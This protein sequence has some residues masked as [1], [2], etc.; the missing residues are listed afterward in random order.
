MGIKF[1]EKITIKNLYLSYC[2]QVQHSQKHDKSPPSNQLPP[3]T[4]A[5][6][7]SWCNRLHYG[8][9]NIPPVL[10]VDSKA[11]MDTRMSNKSLAIFCNVGLLRSIYFSPQQDI[12]IKRL[13]YFILLQIVIQ[14]K[15]TEA[16]LAFFFLHT[17][18]SK[19][20]NWSFIGQW[21][22]CIKLKSFSCYLFILALNW[23]SLSNS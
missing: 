13:R 21:S 9:N 15:F 2:L 19:S 14:F 23:S 8:V 18:K 7:V 1:I 20:A 3:Q 10:K 12:K 11:M 4:K 17:Y 6:T 22:F 16:L 5:S